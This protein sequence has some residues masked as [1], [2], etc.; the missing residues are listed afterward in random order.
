MRLRGKKTLF[1]QN[2][3]GMF[4]HPPPTG[5]HIDKCIIVFNIWFVNQNA[6]L[7]ASSIS[8][9]NLLLEA[10]VSTPSLGLHITL[11]S[12]FYIICELFYCD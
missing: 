8:D 1:Y 5:I 12:S 4:M 7:Y 2:S 10:M 11:K 9:L 3:S 6:C